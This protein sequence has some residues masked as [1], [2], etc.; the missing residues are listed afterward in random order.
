[1]KVNKAKQLVAKG[2]ALLSKS[3]FRAAE[4]VFAE[5]LEL[6][7]AIPIRNNLATAVF[8]GG[9]LGR[10]LK[11]LEPCL[12][13]EDIEAN[14]YTYALAARI[15]C[16]LHRDEEARRWLQ[17][18]VDSFEEG[19][20]LAQVPRPFRE[21]TVAIMRAAADLGDHRYVLDLYHRWES[22][23]IRW[24]NRFMAAVA[25]FNMG[26]YGRA[27]DLWASIGHVHKVFPHM[28]QVAL[29]AEMGVI[30]PFQ[31][32]YQFHSVEDMQEII[33]RAG[34]SKEGQQRCMQDGSVRMF[35]LSWVLA[36]HSGKA[37]QALYTMI[38]F[39][40]KWGEELG[41]QFLEYPDLP[42]SLKF[43]AADA[44]VARGIFKENEPI[45]MFI[46]GKRRLVV[47]KKLPVITEPDQE[48][49]EMVD[50]AIRLRDNGQLEEAEA[51]L[52]KIYQEGRIYPPAM[53][54]L[55]NILRQRDKLQESLV[56]MEMLADMVPDDP[57]LLFNLSALMLQMG[58]VE[59]AREYFNKVDKNA[60]GEQN[61]DKL[62]FLEKEIKKA[63]L[64]HS[65]FSPEDFI[66]DLEERQ[67]TE[68]EKKPLPVDAPLSRG[69]KNMPAH[70]LECACLS[71]HLEPARVRQQRE[72]QL[73][74]FLTSRSNLEQ[75]VE[76]LGEEERELLRYLLQRGGWSR[77]NAVTRKFG[78]LQGDGYFWQER[79]PVSTLG[80][81]WS[82]ALV[83]V[84]RARVGGNQCKIVVV[85][86][87]LRQIL[88]DI[89]EA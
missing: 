6:D 53:M 28:Q 89:L 82:R 27:A 3:D 74:E 10:A 60:L 78:S 12:K 29:L 22:L 70:W 68:V 58:K 23:H 83:F 67:R 39:G 11:I 75:V 56:I 44:L 5:A 35:L 59:Q 79:E 45:P 42:P 20:G 52:Q 2:S 8:M 61:E 26:N 9:E 48:L 14:P 15:Y 76:A 63:E 80:T 86:L 51:L 88:M 34:N 40:G 21:Y 33:L 85:P 17:R 31:M 46:D 50:R 71:H 62:K 49:D 16:A 41:R 47:L 7:N 38:Y 54:T 72:A 25:C 84:G 19:I 36:D 69:L 73:R 1:M 77:M 32:G 64:V 24:E 30:P 13:M 66:A 81:L 57:A 55:A 37:G 65:L 4:K 87:E 18:A 43:A